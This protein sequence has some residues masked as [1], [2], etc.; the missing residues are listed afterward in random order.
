MAQ[1]QHL[2]TVAVVEL[3]GTGVQIWKIIIQGKR[4]KKCSQ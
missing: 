2:E 4:S 1:V 3:S